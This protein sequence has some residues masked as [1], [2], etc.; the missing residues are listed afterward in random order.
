M[1]LEG[2]SLWARDVYPDPLHRVRHYI[3][4]LQAKASKVK[5]E[6]LK[7]SCALTVAFNKKRGMI[8]IDSRL[9]HVFVLMQK[10]RMGQLYWRKVCRRLILAEMLNWALLEAR[11]WNK[12]CLR[13]V[14]ELGLYMKNRRTGKLRGTGDLILQLATT[15]IFTLRIRFVAR[16]GLKQRQRT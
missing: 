2:I 3:F 9:T 11:N 7:L 8:A 13:K 6:T 12:N 1:Q 15:R 14:V 16:A 5:W 10:S 4:I